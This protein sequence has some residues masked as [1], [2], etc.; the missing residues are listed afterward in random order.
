M[1]ISVYDKDLFLADFLA[2]FLA[3]G[4]A[5]TAEAGEG[6]EALARAEVAMAAMAEAAREAEAA[7]AAEALQEARAGWIRWRKARA[8]AV[9]AAWEEGGDGGGGDGGGGGGEGA[10]AIERAAVA[11]AAARRRGRVRVRQGN[12]VTPSPDGAPTPCERHRLMTANLATCIHYGEINT[13]AKWKYR[14][15]TL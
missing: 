10:A 8:E 11:R 9:A 6:Q 14:D 5:A 3:S 12:L 15:W 4:A 1:S 2:D 13:P 7:R